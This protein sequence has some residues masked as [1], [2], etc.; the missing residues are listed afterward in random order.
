[1]SVDTIKIVINDDK[2]WS[3]TLLLDKWNTK[4]NYL[5]LIEYASP[6]VENVSDGTELVRKSNTLNITC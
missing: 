3:K 4:H 6:S 1:M 2:W 5:I